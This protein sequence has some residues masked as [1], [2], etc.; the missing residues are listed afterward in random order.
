MPC[1]SKLGVIRQVPPKL[2]GGKAPKK[3]VSREV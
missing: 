3:R 2:K 1:Q